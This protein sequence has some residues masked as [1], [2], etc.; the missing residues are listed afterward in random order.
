MDSSLEDPA[1]SLLRLRVRG[2][3]PWQVV[4]AAG[5][6][7]LEVHVVQEDRSLSQCC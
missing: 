1:L 6:G 4:V 5:V 2:R 7:A 3:Q